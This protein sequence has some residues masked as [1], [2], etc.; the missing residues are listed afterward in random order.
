VIRV[1]GLADVDDVLIADVQPVHREA[2]V[3]MVALAQA[4]RLAPPVPRAR[5][6]LGQD[7]DVLHEAH[8]HRAD[9][10]GCR[11]EKLL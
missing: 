3:G 1:V 2:E 9:L 7:Q 8:A 5:R 10:P 6:I 11:L 4:E